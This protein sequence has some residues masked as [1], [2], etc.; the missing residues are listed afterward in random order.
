MPALADISIVIPLADGERAWC[1]LLP[2]L[3]ARA[4]ACEL[5]LSAVDGDAQLFPAAAHVVRGPAGRAR[6]LNA[7][8]AVAT[9]PWLWLLHADSRLG[10]RTLDALRRAPEGDYLGYFDLGFHDGPAA[11][12]LNAW[13]AWWRSRL[14]ALPFGDQG[15]LLRRSLFAAL[16]R[17]DETL[18]SGEDHALVW[19]ARRAGVPLAPLGATLYSS[20]RK[21]Q[22]HGWW[23]TTRQHARCTLAQARRFARP[24]A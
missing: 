7:G 9:R 12:R 11:A 23:R 24:P 1:E 4:A 3:A 8:A 19:T 18:A 14:F 2:A 10:P 15:F 17:F 6:Q 13:G 5:L 22:Q 21:Y 20:A 16:G